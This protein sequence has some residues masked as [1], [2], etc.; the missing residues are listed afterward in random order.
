[1]ALRC[2]SKG[3]KGLP[4]QRESEKLMEAKFRLPEL[5]LTWLQE[6]FTLLCHEKFINY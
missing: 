4:S 3:K 6:L 1:M 5:R 2:D